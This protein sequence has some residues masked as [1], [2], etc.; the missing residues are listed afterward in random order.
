MIKVNE[1]FRKAIQNSTRQSYF[2][3][4]YGLYLPQ[5]KA[6]I[7]S[8][9]TELGNNALPFFNPEDIYNDVNYI[10]NKYVTFEPGAFNFNDTFVMIDS[11]KEINE[12]QEV[13]YWSSDIS[14]TNGTFS[15]PQFI[16][17]EFNSLLD[18]TE[19]SL[20]TSEVMQELNIEYKFNDSVLFT[21][22]VRDNVSLKIET[23]TGIESQSSS[24]K[25]N[26]LKI[27]FIKTKTAQRYV[28]FL[29][30]QFGVY[31]TVGKKEIDSIDIVDEMSI[32]SSQLSANTMNVTLTSSNGDYDVLNPYNKLNFLKTRQQ[33]DVY[34]NL[35]VDGVYQSVQLGS[36]LLKSITTTDSTKVTLECYDDIYF[37]NQ[38]YYKSK[39]YNNEPIKN[40]FQDIFNSIN[41]NNEQ[42]T[43]DDDLNDIVLTGY[44]PIVETREALRI[45]A[46]AGAVVISKNRTGEIYIYKTLN[47]P[48]SK[49]FKQEQ[50][51]NS[52]PTRNLY[53]DAVDIN[54]YSYSNIGEEVELYKQTLGVGEHVIQFSDYP[55]VYEKYN[56]EMNLLKKEENANY[57]VIEIS[58]VACK[59]NVFEE[60]EVYLTGTIY[61][62]EISITQVISDSTTEDAINYSIVNVD[63]TLITSSNATTVGKWKVNRNSIKYNFQ[64]HLIPYVE[65]G[66]TCQFESG[67]RTTSGTKNIR[68]NFVPTRT[69]ISSSFWQTIEG[70]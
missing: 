56:T 35:R 34:Y 32:D 19:L 46:E 36:Y 15:T 27:N 57:E 63:N 30:I 62:E 26:K 25:F 29:E 58:A 51:Q 69:T 3:L 5:A 68:R 70:E 42:Y 17:Y 66:D 54:S 20:Y 9:N 64:T 10:N 47:D 43:L 13:G 65:L 21:Y 6:K 8:I 2:S 48:L 1:Q 44:I 61:S 24:I 60:T 4:R 11:V 14:N 33:I 7:E 39:F 31:Q 55:L 12:N 23:K 37:M 40:I 45:V 28:K 16:E 50:Y 18:F 22:N 53:D 38:L 52:K 67:Y 41:Y 59:V 49:I